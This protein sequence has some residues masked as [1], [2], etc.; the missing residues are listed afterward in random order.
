MRRRHALRFAAVRS[1]IAA[2]PVIAMEYRTDRMVV[3]LAANAA[4][5]RPTVSARMSSIAEMMS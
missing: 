3:G 5:A 1:L 4:R 2:S